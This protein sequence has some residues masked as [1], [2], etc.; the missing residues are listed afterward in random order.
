M[1]QAE[2]RSV[3]AEPN[4]SYRLDGVA[5]LPQLVIEVALSSG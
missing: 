3:S 4:L 5:G 2:D 1:V